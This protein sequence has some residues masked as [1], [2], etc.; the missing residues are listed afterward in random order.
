MKTVIRF[1][2]LPSTNAKALEL[3]KEGTREAAIA[4]DVQ[5]AGRGRMGRSFCSPEGG[6]YMSV[7]TSRLT[8]GAAVLALTPAAALAVRSAVFRTFGLSCA[9]KYPNDLILD[10]K[11]VCGILCES[12]SLADRFSVVIGVGVNVNSDIVL[13]EE[14]APGEYPPA[15][16]NAFCEKAEDPA[17]IAQLQQAVLEE[18]QTL[19][20]SFAAGGTLDEAAYRS[21]CLNCPDVIVP[22]E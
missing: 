8:P 1:E 3:A 22:Y 16:L 14:Q 11:K 10:G 12:I 9:V 2:S 13:N 7:L 18:L 6:L 17:A 20:D 21:V 19:I 4:A 5:T 15:S